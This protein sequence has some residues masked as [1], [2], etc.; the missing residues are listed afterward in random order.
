MKKTKSSFFIYP[1]HKSLVLRLVS[2]LEI[3][4]LTGFVF[5]TWSCFLSKGQ[6]VGGRVALRLFL[7]SRSD[8][9]RL[10]LLLAYNIDLVRKVGN[11][12]N[13][14]KS[15]T[16]KERLRLS[17]LQTKRW[18]WAYIVFFDEDET[19]SFNIYIVVAIRYEY[20][21]S[22]WCRL[23]TPISKAVA[24]CFLE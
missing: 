1:H 17:L 2:K 15:E 22:S 5:C 9:F 8:I 12:C 3:S 21:Q 4:M 20:I 24:L 19:G 11:I 13:Q 6:W 16:K 14:S 10:A 7:S 18:N 23:L